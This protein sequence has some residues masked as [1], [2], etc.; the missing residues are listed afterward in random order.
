[1]SWKRVLENNEDPVRLYSRQQ[2]PRY[3]LYRGHEQPRPTDGEHSQGLVAGFT[4]KYNVKQLVYYEMHETMHEAIRR[5]KQLKEWRRLWKI[6]IIE[7]FNP[8]WR[9]LFDEQTGEVAFGPAEADRLAAEP[10]HDTEVSGPRPPS[11]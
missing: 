11:G 1:M 3:A 8:E 6:R 10:L 2:A 9:N 5:E 7:Q 4:K